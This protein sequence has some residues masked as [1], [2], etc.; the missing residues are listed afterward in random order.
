MLQPTGS[1]ARFIYSVIRGTAPDEGA[2]PPEHV[3]RSWLRCIN[4]YGLDPQSNAEAVVVSREE[5]LLCKDRNADLV[6]FADTEM[7]QLYQQLAGSGH[8]IIL[9]DREGVLVS[10][11]G[12]PGFKRAASRTG[13][14]LGA[15][16]SERYG[17]TNGMGTCLFERAPVIIHRDQHFLTRNTG[18]TCCAAPIF[19]HRGELV[20]VLDASG[21]SDRAQQHTLV[22]VNMSAQMIENRLF[23]HRFRDAF[24][25]RFHS[26]PELVGTWSE[27]IIA[28]GLDGAI[29][30]VDR[31][32]LFQLGCKSAGELTGA[33]LERL[34]NISL[35]ALV[36]RS[37]RKSF[38]PL[39]IYEARHGGRFFAV[40]QEPESRLAGTGPA[41]T[42]LRAGDAAPAAGRSALDELNFGDEVM[43]RN[44][45]AARHVASRD[46]PILLIGETGTGKERFARAL[47]AAGDRAEKPF[48]AVNCAAI[49]E[50]LVA[51]ELFGYRASADAAAPREGL[52]GKIAQANGG[53]L[54]LDEIGA[55]PLSVQAR[56]LHLLE[57]REIIALDTEVPIRVDVRLVSAVHSGL[58]ERIAQGAFRDDL[59]YRLQGLVLTL[60]RLRERADKRELVLH[61]F[62]QEAAAT[63]AV[64][65]SGEVIQALCAYHW[66]GNIRQLRNVLRAMIALRRADRLELGDVPV[67]CRLRPPSADPAPPSE[68]ASLNALGKAERDALFHELEAEHGNIS[69]VARKLGVSRNT[70]YRKMQRLHI[71]WPL[72]KPPY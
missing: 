16:W 68:A 21:E 17:G 50:T 13:L 48:V 39:P 37:H 27:G 46:V 38:H 47:H 12:D 59:F 5:F 23:L 51:N 4:Q 7:A 55:L 9:T 52:H 71:P 62:A 22:L 53:T 43:A 66:P 63:P 30:A 19:D 42:S 2:K 20:A 6:S 25:V 41:R 36:A 70:L 54:F 60:P 67:E 31:N 56:L 10:Y 61:V 69:H 44:I 11:Y 3:K 28:L 1:H 35:P 49:P 33:P 64:S 57:E 34:F 32:A 65:L 24:V 40:A 8:S 26:R 72:K 29:A 58:E 18:L 14:V 15:L 45:Q